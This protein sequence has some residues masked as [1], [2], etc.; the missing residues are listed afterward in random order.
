MASNKPSRAN[1]VRLNNIRVAPRK[2][3]ILIDLIRHKD[4][5]EALVLL[6]YSERGAARDV[7]KL[8]ASGVANIR[9]QRR[10]WDVD[11]LYVSRAWVDAGPTLKR[12]KPRAQGRATP[13]LKRTSQVTIELRPD[14]TDSE[15]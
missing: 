9:Q 7:A 5:E 1:I 13:V 10:D 6:Q 2:L 11:S 3:R 15:D 4:V 14:I 8:L 12:F